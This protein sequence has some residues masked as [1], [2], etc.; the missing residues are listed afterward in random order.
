MQVKEEILTRWGE[1]GISIKDS[2]AVFDLSYV[3][4]KE[5]NSDKS[6]EFSW[7][8]VKIWYYKAKFNKISVYF[9]EEL[10]ENIDGNTLT[11]EISRMLFSRD[12]EIHHI[13]VYSDSV[14]L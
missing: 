11:K 4:K 5:F 14:K 9:N 10:C 8:G 6:V 1:L 3:D 13:E 12:G 2:C 7:C